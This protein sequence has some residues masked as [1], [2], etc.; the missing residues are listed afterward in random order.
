MSPGFEKFLKAMGEKINMA[1]WDGYRGDMGKHGETYHSSWRGCEIIYH[2]APLM[3][4]EQHR[5]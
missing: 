4:A 3:G 2:I 1:K 5:R